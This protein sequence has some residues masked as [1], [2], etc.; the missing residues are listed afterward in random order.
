VTSKA[1]GLTVSAGGMAWLAGVVVVESTYVDSDAS[2]PIA[3]PVLALLGGASVGWGLWSVA[4]S[5][6]LR[7]ARLGSRLVGASAMALGAGFGVELLPG[8]TGLGFL[9][10]YTFG[11]FVFP[12]ALIILGLGVLRSVVFPGWAKWVPLATAAAGVVTY[13]FHALAP[14]IWDPSDAVW[15]ISI[16]VSWVLL[17]LA[18]LTIPCAA[19]RGQA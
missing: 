13:G 8:D 6:D 1:R 17:G 16:G 18:S 2:L 19:R 9:L 15:Y 5:I 4:R 7:L 10:A 12:I 14:E 3:F 11:L